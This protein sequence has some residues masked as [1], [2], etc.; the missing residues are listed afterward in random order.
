MSAVDLESP[1]SARDSE[2]LTFDD[3]DA[4]KM[5]TVLLIQSVSLDITKVAKASKNRTYLYPDA[6]YSTPTV[7]HILMRFGFHEHPLRARFCI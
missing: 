4:L 5:N 2:N 1:N 3:L 6:E 7:W